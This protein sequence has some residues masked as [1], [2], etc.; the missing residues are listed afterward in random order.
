MQY[1]WV[2]ILTNEPLGTLCTGVTADLERRLAERR[3][4]VGSAFVRRYNLHRLVFAEH[5]ANI[6]QAIQRETSLK[7]WQREWKTDLIETANPG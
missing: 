2:Y 6:E 3:S 4:G 5:H 7:R 1:G